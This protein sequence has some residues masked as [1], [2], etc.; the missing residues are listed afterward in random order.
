[1]VEFD[2]FF[3]KRNNMLL[4]PDVMVPVEYG[5]GLAQENAGIMHNRG[6]EFM[7]GTI[8]QFPSGIRLDVSGNFT[9]ARNK[10]IQIFENQSTY[11]DPL[12]RRTGR[13]YG[14]QFGYIALGLFQSQ[15]EIDNSPRQQLG[16]Y[17]VGDIKYA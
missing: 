4:T 17:T 16:S 6:V 12:R 7:I 1:R 13:P 5:I 15:E 3:Q 8:H 11:N 9:Y 2:Y 14:A 10:M